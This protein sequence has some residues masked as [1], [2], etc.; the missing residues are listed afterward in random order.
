MPRKRADSFASHRVSLVRHRRAS[1]LV[2]FKGFFH[3]FEIR[4]QSDIRSYLVRCRSERRQGLQDVYIDLPR[5][6]LASNRVSI[7]ESVQFSDESIELFDFIVISFEQSQETS[8]STRRA[9]DTSEANIGIRARDIP[10]IPEK[11]LDP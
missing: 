6:C 8:L 10:Q 4:Q 7:F 1:N 2:L 3:L 9:F 5:V 11:L